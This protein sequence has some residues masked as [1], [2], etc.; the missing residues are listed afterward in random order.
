M[1]NLYHNLEEQD[2]SSDQ[3]DILPWLQASG[4]R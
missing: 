1:L 2:F 4:A 3:K